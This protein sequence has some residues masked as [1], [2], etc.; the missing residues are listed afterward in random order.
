MP[1]LDK[2]TE[3]RIKMLESLARIAVHSASHSIGEGD[4]LA[5][6]FDVVDHAK[7]YE[8]LFDR[9]LEECPYYWKEHF[10]EEVRG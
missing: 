3:G 9:K 4:I 5:D 7:E 8:K 6:H 2:R 1:S 10:E